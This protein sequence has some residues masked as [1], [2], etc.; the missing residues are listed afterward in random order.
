[1]SEV[2]TAAIIDA[3]VVV[4]EELH[5]FTDADSQSVA[6]ALSKI[7]NPSEGILALAEVFSKSYDISINFTPFAEAEAEAVEAELAVV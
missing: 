6:L 1:M 7:K 4:L 3:D 2:S 5:N